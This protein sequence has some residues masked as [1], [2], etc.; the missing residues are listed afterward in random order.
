MADLTQKQADVF[1]YIKDHI[2]INGFPPTRKEMADAFN[3]QPNSIQVRINAL[4]KKG[5]LT[6]GSK[7]MR[8]TLPV[9]GFRVRIK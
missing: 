9:K 7:Q 3:L 5:A 8:A 2:T 6:V 4:V 1:F